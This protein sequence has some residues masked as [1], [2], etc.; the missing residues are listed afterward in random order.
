MLS[1]HFERHLAGSS[2]GDIAH[3][4]HQQNELRY[5][6][7]RYSF[8]RIFIGASRR[9]GSVSYL[10]RGLVPKPIRTRHHTLYGKLTI[11]VLPVLL[12]RK[13]TDWVVPAKCETRSSMPGLT[14]YLRTSRHNMHSHHGLKETNTLTLT[15]APRE[16]SLAFRYH[17]RFA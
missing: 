16:S 17:T 13:G 14:L 3:E 1:R 4:S 12:H 2:P 15:V 10:T 9:S 7:S 11:C 6:G 5:Q 8:L